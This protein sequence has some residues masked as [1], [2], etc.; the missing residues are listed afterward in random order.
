MLHERI[1]NGKHVLVLHGPPE[2]S[3]LPPVN[4]DQ[5]VLIRHRSLGMDVAAVE[6]RDVTPLNTSDSDSEESESLVVRVRKATQPR[7]GVE[8]PLGRFHC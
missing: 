3:V 2:G 6:E 8:P 4:V 1:L 5:E 7:G